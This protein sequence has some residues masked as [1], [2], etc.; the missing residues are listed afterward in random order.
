MT[1]SAGAPRIYRRADVEQVLRIKHLLLV[2]GLTLAGV[3]RKIEDEAPIELPAPPLPV[4]RVGEGTRERL[5]E[6][7]QGL[8]ALLEM[9]S[10][11]VAVSAD[12]QRGSSPA[13]EGNAAD[14]TEQPALGDFV[15]TPAAV[16]DRRAEESRAQRP[17]AVS[18]IETTKGA[19]PAAPT[20]SP[21]RKRSA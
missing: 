3:R 15:L 7:K 19:P 8:R 12:R 1:K 20:S 4:S 6:V 9:L 5:G 14:R 11:P 10:A 16:D 21:R 17:R 18:K 13:A 2:E